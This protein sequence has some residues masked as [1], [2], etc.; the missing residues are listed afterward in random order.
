MGCRLEYWDSPG[1]PGHMT[2]LGECNGEKWEEWDN[3]VG[4]KE[5][6]SGSGGEAVLVI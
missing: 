1:F 2:T 3:D 6:G 4:G 5:C